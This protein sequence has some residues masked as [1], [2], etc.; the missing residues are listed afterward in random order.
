MVVSVGILRSSVSMSWFGCGW[1]RLRSG[2]AGLL[3][4][5]SGMIMGARSAFSLAGGAIVVD[6]GFEGMRVGTALCMCTAE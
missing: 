5:V 1:D 2:V 3:V 4:G 6:C